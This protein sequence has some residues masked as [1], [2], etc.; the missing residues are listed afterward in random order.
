MKPSTRGAFCAAALAAIA[1]ST[2][3]AYAAEVSIK[4][5]AGDTN[6]A[7]L[8][9]DAAPGEDNQLTIR[10]R[11]KSGDFLHL[12][13]LDAGAP[14][15]PG[16]GCTGGGALG[17][18]VA[19]EM[20]VPRSTEQKSDGKI[21][22]PVPGTGWSDSMSIQ[23]GDGNNV[24]DGS[25]FTARYAES[26]SMNVVSGAGRDRV[27]T[28]G[29]YD[30]VDPGP[31][32]DEVHSGGADDRVEATPQPDGPDLY[33][34]GSSGDTISYQQRTTP[35]IVRGSTGGAP[36]EKD[37][38]L[39]AYELIG[40]SA[41]DT[42]TGRY[43]Q[44]VGGPGDDTLAIPPRHDRR[45]GANFYSL[46]GGPGDDTLSAGSGRR[47]GYDD[48]HGGAGADVLYGREGEDFLFGGAGADVIHGDGGPDRIQAG[49]GNDVSFGGPGPDVVVGETDEG[50]EAPT[51][52]P[53]D[54]TI[55]GGRGDDMIEEGRGS[56]R[57]DGGPGRD[58]LDGGFGADRLMGGG[59]RDFLV[60]DKG[61]DRLFGG[62]G[63]DRLLSGR[64]RLDEDAVFFFGAPNDGH[65]L[66]D[67]GPGHDFAAAN[68][69]DPSEGCETV[70]IVRPRKID[71]AR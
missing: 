1:L 19:C 58:Q 69:W 59:S 52:G 63:S 16:P 5:T 41:G 46:E 56:D 4:E 65:D 64:Y 2:A 61:F 44:I 31:G 26:V 38:I 25:S 62:G 47:D 28:G 12:E 22:L 37:S 71:D 45:E 14:V 27:L 33:D 67:C 42:L 18:P 48:V 66:V 11:S 35:V 32:L 68:P 55:Y 36:G 34:L 60:G 50:D 9:F 3:P 10:S 51:D 24:F 29:G 8:T 30:K 40:G 23:L 21:V 70:R 39:G 53:D 20:H 17:T 13:V 15:N 43:G 49:T 57:L 54:D 6:T 7:V